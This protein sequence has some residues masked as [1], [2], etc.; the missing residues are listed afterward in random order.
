[1]HFFCSGVARNF[2]TQ[3]VDIEDPVT[4]AVYILGNFLIPQLTDVDFHRKMVFHQNGSP[5]HFNEDVP[6]FLTSVPRSANRAS[7]SNFWLRLSDVTPLDCYC[8]NYL[9]QSP[10]RS[11]IGC[12]YVAPPLTWYSKMYTCRSFK[13]SRISS[14]PTQPNFLPTTT[15]VHA[16]ACAWSFV[17]MEVRSR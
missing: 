8:Q 6:H 15:V 1:M 4:D 12:Y 3:S 9:Y 17:S 11:Q 7:W 5:P 14:W 10:L 13:A 2:M 16:L